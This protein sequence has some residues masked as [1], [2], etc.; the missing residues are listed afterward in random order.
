M[1]LVTD[2]NVLVARFNQMKAILFR[3]LRLAA[4]YG[5]WPYLCLA[6]LARWQETIH[7]DTRNFTKKTQYCLV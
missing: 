6:V 3:H 7:E 2:N 5:Q 1:A 4:N